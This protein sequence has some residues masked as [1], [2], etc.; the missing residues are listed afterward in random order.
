MFSYNSIASLS[1]CW[2]A[3]EYVVAEHIVKDFATRS[4]SL[5]LLFQADKLLKLLETPLF[6]HLRLHLIDRENPTLCP[7][8]RSLY[9]FLMLLPQ[10][11]LK[12][13]FLNII[14]FSTHYPYSNDSDKILFFSYFYYKYNL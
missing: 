13:L 8:V 4:M 14:P 2:L 9:S 7:M 1:L 10:V 11:I 12:S 3:E 6:A 5:D